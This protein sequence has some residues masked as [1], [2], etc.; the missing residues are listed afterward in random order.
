MS[1]S[2]ICAQCISHPRRVGGRAGLRPAARRVWRLRLAREHEAARGRADSVFARRAWNSA[3]CAAATFTR[4]SS[5]TER[6]GGVR[7]PPPTGRQR[8]RHP[9]RG[10]T[11]LRTE[12]LAP[13]A[14]SSDAA[15]RLICGASTDWSMRA[16]TCPAFTLSPPSTST[17]VMRPLSPS[18]PM[19]MSYRA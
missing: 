19:A 15:S 8:L 16:S 10:D 12:R 5:V 3:S 9:V 6:R 11:P 18:A 2:A 17:A 7:L 1:R 4:A 14:S 13:F